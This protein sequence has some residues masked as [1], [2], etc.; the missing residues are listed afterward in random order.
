VGVCTS[1]APS[2]TLGKSIGLGYLPAAMA[3]IDTEFLV[4][5]RGRD[6]AA[7]VVKTPFYKRPRSS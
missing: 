6:I 7:K 1:G 4:D 5:C 2:P 3:T